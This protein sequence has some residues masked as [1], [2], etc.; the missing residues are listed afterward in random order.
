MSVQS[1]GSFKHVAHMGYTSEHGFSSSGVD[2]SWQALLDQLGSAGISQKQIQENEGF[3]RDF[4]KGQGGLP[5]SLHLHFRFLSSAVAPVLRRL[6]PL[7]TE[8]QD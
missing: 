4:V 3:I 2:P 1:E 5:V 7:W 6:C 8:L